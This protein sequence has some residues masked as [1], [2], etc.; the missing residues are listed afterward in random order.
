METNKNGSPFLKKKDCMKVGI[1]ACSPQGDGYEAEFEFIKI[2]N[3]DDNTK[4]Y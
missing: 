1:Y 3:I 2:E 4:V